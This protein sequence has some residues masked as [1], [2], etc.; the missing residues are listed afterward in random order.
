MPSPAVPLKTCWSK[1]TA[2]MPNMPRMCSL[3][4]S[5]RADQQLKHRNFG[6]EANMSKNHMPTANRNKKQSKTDAGVN[7]A[8][9]QTLGSEQWSRA[10]SQ[11]YNHL[12]NTMPELTTIKNMPQ[13]NKT[14]MQTHVQTTCKPAKSNYNWKTHSEWALQVLA[15]GSSSQQSSLQ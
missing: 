13:N 2:H 5:T 10:N 8:I 12:I 6:N 11:F 4:Q 7:A 15:E 1:Q 14:C 9:Q 3:K